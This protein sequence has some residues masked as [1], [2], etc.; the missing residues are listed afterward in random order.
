MYEVG[1]F[2]VFFYNFRIKLYFNFHSKLSYH[3]YQF[4]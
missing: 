4:S 1:G 2:T 3:L